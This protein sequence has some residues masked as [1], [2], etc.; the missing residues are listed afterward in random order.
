MFTANNLVFGQKVKGKYTIENDKVATSI[1]CEQSATNRNNWILTMNKNGEVIELGKFKSLKNAIDYCNENENDLIGSGE[2]MEVVETVESVETVEIQMIETDSKGQEKL[3]TPQKFFEY[4]WSLENKLDV[5]TACN[6][7][8]D[9]I[10][11]IKIKKPDDTVKIG[12]EPSTKS[13][14]LTKYR[15]LLKKTHHNTTLNEVVATDNGNVTQHIAVNFLRLPDTDKTKLDASRN[16]STNDFNEDG[17]VKVV[18]N[19]PDI[20]VSEIIDTACKLLHSQNFIDVVIGMLIVTGRRGFE[21]STKSVNYGDISITKEMIEL[22]DFIVG[23]KGIAKKRNGCENF[24]KFVTLIPAKIVVESFERLSKFDD[25]KVLVNQTNELYQNGSVRKAISRKF[26]DLFSDKLSSFNAY[27]TDGKLTNEDGSTHKSRAFYACVL[28]E[29][30]SK[31]VNRKTVVTQLVQFNLLHDKIDETN[32]YLSK[33]D[34]YN[35]INIPDNITL[36]TNINHLGITTNE[37]IEMVK[38]ELVKETKENKIMIDFEKLVSKLN[39]DLQVK[40]A[41]NLKDTNNPLESLLMVLNSGES[42]FTKTP[43]TKNIKT[44]LTAITAYN[45]DKTDVDEMVYPTYNLINKINQKMT[46]KQLANK[47]YND[48]FDGYQKT[49]LEFFASKGIDKVNAEKWNNLK[50][51]K[52]NDTIVSTLY[53]SI[54]N[55]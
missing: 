18:D 1:Y 13:K 4:I 29:I 51:R 24:Y 23:F 33:Y 30:Y 10:S 39:S 47:T 40:I 22:D 50:H 42:D 36:T 49:F 37:E 2:K 20:N 3:I 16:K 53:K 11:N 14:V 8:L 45:S 21:I 6:H 9:A 28:Q 32:K 15:N 48:V 54:I 5:N 43:V 12:Y 34:G 26:S 7:L 17:N 35:F 52:D 19:L 41:D 38:S 27:D 55:V 46:G 25:Y 31:S 44:V